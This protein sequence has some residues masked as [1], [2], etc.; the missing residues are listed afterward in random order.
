[1]PVVARVDRS[2]PG[3]IRLADPAARLVGGQVVA[4][5]AREVTFGSVPA[6]AGV[7]DLRIAGANVFH[8][9]AHTVP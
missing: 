2:R 1:M 3:G 6:A 5:W 7:A 9:D 8:V 4:A